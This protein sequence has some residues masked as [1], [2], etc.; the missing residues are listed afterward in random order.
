MTTILFTPKSWAA[1]IRL[2]GDM[3]VCELPSAYWR[4]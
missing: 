1:L 2:V 4:R 3:K